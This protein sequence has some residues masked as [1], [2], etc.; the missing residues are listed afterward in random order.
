MKTLQTFTIIGMLAL[1]Y[2]TYTET[3]SCPKGQVKRGNHC[4]TES[5]ERE[6]RAKEH[7]LMFQINQLVNTDAIENMKNSIINA[8]K[9]FISNPSQ[10][11]MQPILDAINKLSAAMN[12]IQTNAPTL[13]NAFIANRQAG[14]SAATLPQPLVTFSGTSAATT[15]NGGSTT[16]GATTTSTT[17]GAS[18]D[19]SGGSSAGAGM[20]A[21]GSTAGGSTTSTDDGSSTDWD[22]DNSFGDTS[23]NGSSDGSGS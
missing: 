8:V 19:S 7:A 9:A 20:S 14:G 5:R 4:I 16:A 10:T 15:N 2:V 6:D 21:G 22:P 13:L 18:T 1:L 23:S 17:G 12:Q 11:T 3:T